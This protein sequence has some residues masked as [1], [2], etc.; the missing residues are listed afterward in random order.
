MA[1][2]SFILMSK[3]YN[4]SS[5]KKTITD[6]NQIMVQHYL[7]SFTFDIIPFVILIF[8]FTKTTKKRDLCI[9]VLQRKKKILF[10]VK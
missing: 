10:A 5:K 1:K 4:S 3:R 8:F 9:A 6:I 7:V 2:P